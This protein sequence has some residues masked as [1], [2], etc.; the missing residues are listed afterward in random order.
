MEKPLQQ[1]HLRLPPASSA[2]SGSVIRCE[3]RMKEKGDASLETTQWQIRNVTKE[4]V[5]EYRQQGWVFLP[6]FIDSGSAQEILI[7]I[8]S[9]I[10]SSTVTPMESSGS[11]ESM[12]ESF[13]ELSQHSDD[14]RSFT[15]SN[16]FG[17]AAADLEGWPMRFWGD[18]LYKKYPAS[19]S[20]TPWHQ[21]QPYA[22]FD[23]S[24]RPQ[25]WIALNDI[26]PDRGSLR[27]LT[28][29]HKSGLLGRAFDDQSAEMSRRIA[30]RKKTYA[31]SPPLHLCAGDAT[32]HDGMT[33]HS[34]PSNTTAEVRA[35]YILQYFV[36]DMLYTGGRP[37]V[38]DLGIKASRPFDH[39]RFPIVGEPR[40]D[41]CLF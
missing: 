28:G 36:A 21:D 12:F 19:N 6:K 32:V 39:E 31:I 7:V 34:A 33:I 13:D 22:P 30:T 8:E 4:E 26:P 25:F 37:K 40:P 20:E 35:A 27:F 5:D 24:G 29:S 17:R 18:G 3:Y 38:D 2:V 15:H 1:K 10:S 14:L 23:R 9:M 11:V 16:D 41:F